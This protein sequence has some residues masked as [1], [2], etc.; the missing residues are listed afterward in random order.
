MSQLITEIPLSAI[1]S[2]PYNSRLKY[3]E[4]S[5][6][7]IARSLASSGQLCTVKVRHSTKSKNKFELVYGHRRVF[8]AQKLRWRT[9]RAEIVEL[10]DQQMIEQSLIENFEREELSDYEKALIF[11]RLCVVFKKTYEQVGKLVGISKQHVCTYLSMLRLFDQEYLVANPDLV[12]SLHNIAEHHARIISTVHDKETR[13]DLVR[14]TV[15]GKLTVKQLSDTV[16]RLRS[17]FT[18]YDER[19]SD[20][21]P[22]YDV[23]REVS[24][25]ES[26]IKKVVLNEFELAYEGDF[27]KYRDMHLFDEG[28]SMFCST[29]PFERIDHSDALTRDLHWF[30]QVMPRSSYRIDDLKTTVLTEAALCTFIVRYSDPTITNFRRVR[31]TMVLVKKRGDWKVLHEHWSP[32]TNEIER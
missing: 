27:S 21:E 5:N 9:I 8:A 11:Q 23:E 20:I 22:R 28:F 18:E 19:S 32:L 7:R 1:E 2:N 13:A 29:S 16:S 15:R 30:Y 14:M 25:E 10:S 12:D 24:G 6:E 3:S 31:G 26:K 17:W 4:P